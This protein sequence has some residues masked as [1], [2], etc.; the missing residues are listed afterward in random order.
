MSQERALRVMDALA[1]RLSKHDES[2]VSVQEEIAKQF[3]FFRSEVNRIE[4]EI[5]AQL[6]AAFTK[7]DEKLQSTLNELRQK[8]VN[9]CT[10]DELDA[11]C[12]RGESE[13]IVVQSYECESTISQLNLSNHIKL[14]V[15]RN[16]HPARSPGNLR[17]AL[18]RDVSVGFDFLNDIES[19]IVH[20]SGT[21]VD[22]KASI[23]HNGSELPSTL[24]A[25]PTKDGPSNKLHL[26]PFR[27]LISG[28][29]YCVKVGV[30]S[31][32]SGEETWSNPE[33]VVPDF[34]KD[35]AWKKCPE[36]VSSER[37][38]EV[39]E[40]SPRIVRCES[41]DDSSS[42]YEQ[43]GW[44]TI[45]GAVT[46]PAASKVSWGVKI[47]M[48]SWNCSGIYIGVAP[49]DIDQNKDNNYTIC[50]WYFNCYDSTLWSGPPHNYKHPGKEY[51][52]RK[53]KGEYVRKGDTI[54]ISMDTIKGEL[55]FVLGGVSYGIAFE[56]I[57]LDKPLVPCA[58][59][60]YNDDIIELV[61]ENEVNTKIMTQ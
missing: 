33:P 27:A 29:Q 34:Y 4:S 61:S 12:L 46:I 48:T 16:L 37:R 13:L 26:S 31:S 56:G 58:I 11:L 52:P 39:S 5:N 20:S 19:K 15:A 60:W 35:L 30:V 53:N 2:R 14:K 25:A 21:A 44:R 59:L 8:V 49:F 54:N 38:Y 43:N 9:G 18:G 50:G 55:S 41:A 36:N 32:Q 57:P 24:T 47:I 28:E 23:T 10:R 3:A 40:E 51:G 45:I 22:Y 42:D 17:I 7:E 6:Q 1:E